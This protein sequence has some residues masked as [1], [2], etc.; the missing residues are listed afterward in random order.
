[1]NEFPLKEQFCVYLHSTSDGVTYYVG[2]D[3]QFGHRAYDTS[4]IGRNRLYTNVHK[5]HGCKVDILETC[6]SKEELVLRE[7][8][9]ID[10]KHTW[11]SDPKCTIYA[12]NIL[13]KGSI[14]RSGSR[15]EYKLHV[16][17]TPSIELLPILENIAK[18]KNITLDELINRILVQW[19]ENL[20]KNVSI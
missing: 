9:W 19:V 17:H 14:G 13:R 20:Y 11:A 5:N 4:G 1:M 10:N 12:S 16:K 7:E 15:V 6:Q 3:S 8:Y 18:Q 2:K